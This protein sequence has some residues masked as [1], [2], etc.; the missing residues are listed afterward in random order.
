MIKH[1]GG[2]VWSPCSHD[3][4]TANVDEA[5]ALGLTVVVWTVNTEA[6]MRHMIALGVDGIISDYPDVLRRVAGAQGYAVAAPAH[7]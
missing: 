1:A 5:H 7:R 4:T 3:V 6:D 2:S